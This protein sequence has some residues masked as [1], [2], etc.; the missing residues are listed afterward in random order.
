[1]T[2]PLR[3]GRWLT[4]RR[5]RRSKVR[6]AGSDWYGSADKTVMAGCRV[7]NAFMQLVGGIH[8]RVRRADRVGAPCVAECRGRPSDRRGIRRF[9]SERPV[10]TMG[11][12]VGGIDRRACSRA[13]SDDQQPVQALGADGTD[14]PLGVGVR[15]GACT[16]VGSISAPCEAKTSSNLWVNFA[17]RSRST[18]QSRRP[19]PPAPAAG[20]GPA[21]R[22]RRRWGW[23]SLRPGGPAGCPAR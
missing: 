10:W 11:V 2:A 9:Q 1:L 4:R 12:V 13:S 21:G 8:G 19:A 23:R 6:S 3:G 20:C 22:P 18:T 17:S 5:P 16:G 14:P 15:V 7:A